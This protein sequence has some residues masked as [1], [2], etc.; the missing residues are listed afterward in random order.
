MGY[1]VTGQ[2][3][4]SIIDDAGVVQRVWEVTYRADSGVVGHVDI[5][6]G[7]YNAQSVDEAIRQLVDVHDQVSRLGG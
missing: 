1:R 5:P 6:L 4:T 3:Q 7:S 2:R